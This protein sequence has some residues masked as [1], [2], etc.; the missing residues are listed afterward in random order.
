MEGKICPL[1]LIPREPSVSME[2][3]LCRKE[4]CAWW[5]RSVIPQKE[6][7]KIIEMC[8]ILKIAKS[9]KYPQQ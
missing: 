4:K 2:Q 5:C 6:R 3:V 9:I 7:P 8:S 1:L